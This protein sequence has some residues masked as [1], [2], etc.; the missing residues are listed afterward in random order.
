ML[1]PR[2]HA[3]KNKSV[4]IFIKRTG[5]HGSLEDVP[6][7]ITTMEISVSPIGIENA[8]LCYEPTS[9]WVRWCWARL[10]RLTIWGRTP[11]TDKSSEEDAG[12]GE[13]YDKPKDNVPCAGVFLR[14]RCFC[15]QANGRS[16]YLLHM[17]CPYTLD[18]LYPCI[19][20]STSVNLINY[21]LHV[22]GGTKASRWDASSG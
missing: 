7:G 1:Q 18:L 9:P 17:L 3:A 12:R 6:S 13:N 8:I 19:K 21:G 11:V 15:Q 10:F 4:H 22:P 2:L 16:G 20:L 5:F 14:K